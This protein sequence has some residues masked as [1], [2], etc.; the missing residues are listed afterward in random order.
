ISSRWMLSR[1]K[2]MISYCVLKKS[3]V[4]LF[5]VGRKKSVGGEPK[6][7][8]ENGLNAPLI[9]NDAREKSARHT[10]FDGELRNFRMIIL[11]DEK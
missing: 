7:A 11:T 5:E 2:W 6:L 9:T 4:V 1:L 3:G 8:C 10:S